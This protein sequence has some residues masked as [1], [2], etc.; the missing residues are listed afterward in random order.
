MPRDV[1]TGPYAT[2]PKSRATFVVLGVVFGAFGIHNFYAGYSG[3]G[4][5]QLA[6][7]ICTLFFGGII[8]WIWAIV[9]VC[10]VDR[11]SRNI[12]ML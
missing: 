2:I 8:S 3:R 4:A 6:I 11:D 10:T 9:E 12:V 1:P 7:T 5:A